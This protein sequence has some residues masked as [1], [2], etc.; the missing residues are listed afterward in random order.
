MGGGNLSLRHQ[1]FHDKNF[2]GRS[3]HRCTRCHEHQPP[4]A[5]LPA[6]AQTKLTHHAEVKK[7]SSRL[8]SRILHV[9]R[10]QENQI[11]MPSPT[12][13]FDCIAAGVPESAA[14]SSSSKD[15]FKKDDGIFEDS[16]T[17]KI[18]YR[19]SC[20]KHP[21]TLGLSMFEDESDSESD[22]SDDN[23]DN[24]DNFRYDE[25]TIP[26]FSCQDRIMSTLEQAQSAT[27][28][29]PRASLQ[30][31]ESRHKTRATKKALQKFA[32]LEEKMLVDLTLG[33]TLSKR[34]LS[35]AHETSARNCQK[36]HVRTTDEK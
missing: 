26:G 12:S 27:F 4:D 5:T 7:A 9:P 34:L 10:E 6:S 28:S 23:G 35:H 20:E 30:R 13:S 31:N 2:M 3:K 17:P 16:L 8:I 1:E 11:K 32:R 24:D 25:T 21:Y 36:S 19:V 15:T 29:E 33:P 18:S 22:E 14:L